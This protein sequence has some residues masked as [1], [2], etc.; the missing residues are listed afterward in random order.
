M[1]AATLDVRK[2]HMDTS[3]DG[4]DSSQDTQKLKNAALESVE[5][6]VGGLSQNGVA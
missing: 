1:M 4:R 6:G 5:E 3:N 2:P